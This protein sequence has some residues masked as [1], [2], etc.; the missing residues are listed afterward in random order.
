M[1]ATPDPFTGA[2]PST[3][4]PSVNVTNP[5]ALG[6]PALHDCTDAVSFNVPPVRFHVDGVNATCT[7]AAVTTKFAVFGPAAA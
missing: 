3:V 7:G 1:L 6:G 2:E 4:A 5:F